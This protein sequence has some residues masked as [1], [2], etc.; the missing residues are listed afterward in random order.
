[1]IWIVGYQHF[2]DGLKRAMPFLIASVIYHQDY[3]KAK[4]HST[5]PLWKSRMFCTNVEVEGVRYA[6]V[7]CYFKDKILPGQFQCRSTNMQ[8]SGIPNHLQVVDEICTLREEVAEVKANLKESRGEVIE[9]V[10]NV[11]SVVR[12]QV[13]SVP[14]KVKDCILENFHVEGVQP[15]TMSTLQAVL[16]RNNAHILEQMTGRFRDSIAHFGVRVQEDTAT[17]GLDGNSRLAVSPFRLFQWGGMLGRMVPCGF[18]FPSC[19]IKTMWD[20]WHFGKPSEGIRP[21]KY[22]DSSLHGNFHADLTT[23]DDKENFSRAKKVILALT[24]HICERK[25][26]RKEIFDTEFATYDLI[27]SD[28]L[29]EEH[30]P[31]FITTYYEHGN[32]KSLALNYTTLSNRMYK[33]NPNKK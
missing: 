31:S 3:L 28:Q 18:K 23:K 32:N 5:H 17:E 4:L 25:G 24:E 26:K 11:E 19:D 8:A 1:V 30:F 29:Y 10:S 12:S 14:E 9:A 7:Y 21:Y 13:D 16:D 22:L 33:Q 15:V 27:E 2:P 20:L 6:N